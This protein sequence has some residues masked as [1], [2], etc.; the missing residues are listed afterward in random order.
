MLCGEQYVD[1]ESVDERLNLVILKIKNMVKVD[2]RYMNES[3]SSIN[4]SDNYH[5]PM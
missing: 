1:L 5:S 2:I 3:I 4:A